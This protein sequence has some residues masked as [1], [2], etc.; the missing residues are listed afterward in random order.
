M[1]GQ[2]LSTVVL[3]ALPARPPDARLLV[4]FS[5]GLDSTVLLHLLAS[6]RL[7]GLQAVHVHHGLQAAA[8]D[9]AAH[10]AT[11][12]ASLHVPMIL[13]R[14]QVRD[15]GQG[16]EASAREARYAALREQMAEGDLLATAHH[17]DDQAETL[18][19]RLLRGSGPLGLAAMRP[20][21]SFPPGRLWR[22]L[23]EVSR[24]ELRAYAERQGLRWIE[25]PH[26]AGPEFA[27]SYLRREI[28]PRLEPHWPAASRTLARAAELQ[29]EAADLLRELAEVDRR[30][31]GE[32]ASPSMPIAALRRLSRA[33]QHNLL[34]AWIEALGLPSPYH[35]TL[36]R[37]ET[38]VFDA[39]ADADPVLAWPGGEF[40]RYRGQLF[41]MA[42]LPPVP[43]ELR[44]AW[45]GR[46]ALC[47]PAG[48][49]RLDVREGGVPG[50]LVRLV[51]PGEHFRPCGSPR[52]RSLKN[53]FQ[54]RGVPTW[55][56]A[57]TPMLEREGRALWIG[58]IGWAEDAGPVQAEIEW[59]GRP[60]GAPAQERD[61]SR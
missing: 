5:G 55:V 19:L 7:S 14:V 35:D 31:F 22:P 11:L 3:N 38:E 6:L 33:R 61:R 29:A 59:T 51:E 50:A 49:G 32:E 12:C 24:A 8:E 4:A 52:T 56:R 60:P 9:W 41:V 13:C 17:R 57:R 30:A 47:L 25:D 21:L 48:C 16:V 2:A 20:L 15:A 26:N 10:C 43:R 42:P 54:E 45:D 27:R 40:R 58:G 39:A 28:L 53:L 18:L 34:R 46:G 37:L 36:K 44:L 1:S 23:L